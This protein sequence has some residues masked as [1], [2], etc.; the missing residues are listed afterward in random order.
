MARL[1]AFLEESGPVGPEQLIKMATANVADAYSMRLQPPRQRRHLCL[2]QRIW[3]I[4][5]ACPVRTPRLG[6]CQVRLCGLDGEPVPRAKPS[7]P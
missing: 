7:D 1:V 3:A 5:T 2:K 6:S 4:A